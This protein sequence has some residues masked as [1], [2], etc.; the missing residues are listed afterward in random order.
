ME[1]DEFSKVLVG[2]MIPM[3]V[4]LVEKAFEHLDVNQTGIVDVSSFNLT[5]LD[6]C[7]SEGI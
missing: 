2:P 7:Y 6:G 3:R 1:Y 5:N 4:R